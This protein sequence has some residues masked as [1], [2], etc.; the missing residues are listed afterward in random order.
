[1]LIYFCDQ[2]EIQMQGGELLLHDA[3]HKPVKR[4]APRHNL[5]VAFPCSVNSTHSVAPITSLA[6]PR[7]YVQVHISSSVDIWDDSVKRRRQDSAQSFSYPSSAAAIKTQP[8]LSSNP[9]ERLDVEKSRARL[10]GVL[11]GSQDITIIRNAGNNGDSLIHAGMRQLLKGRDYREVSVWQFGAQRGETAIL[12][13]SGA[14]CE[15]HQHLPAYL[16]RIEQQFERVIVFPSSFDTSVQ[17]VREVLSRTRALVFAREFT[18]F[19]QIRNLCRADVAH[20]TAFFF[21]F[22]PYR[23]QGQGTLLAFRTDAEALTPTVPT[24]NN[25]IAMTCESVDEFLWTIAQHEVVRTDRAHVMIAA[26]LL[27]K[28]VHFGESNYHKVR[29]LA[30]SSLW[31]YSLSFTSELRARLTTELNGDR[32][33]H[34]RDKDRLAFPTSEFERV[35]ALAD[36]RGRVLDELLNSKSFRLVSAYWR[37]RRFLST[38]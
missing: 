29:A 10:L 21:D 34:P 2:R 9:A 8:F 20:D 36:E 11:E 17:V 5:M 23:R 3:T 38:R 14:W 24:G 22:E 12:T 35:K 27:G 37:L 18:S 13:G 28:E 4:I 19:E 33:N 32:P 26:A 31:Q 15:A 16:P 25:D 7:N 30:A 1:M 6:A